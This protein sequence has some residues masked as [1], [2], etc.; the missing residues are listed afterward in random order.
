[1]DKNQLNLES[2]FDLSAKL[3]SSEDKRFILNSALLSIMGKLGITRAAVFLKDKDEFKLIIK[4][5]DIKTVIIDSCYSSGFATIDKEKHPELLNDGFSYSICLSYRDNPSAILLIGK[6]L[7]GNEI[8]QFEEQYCK[9]VS[10]IA[11][12]ALQNAEHFGELVNQKL[13]AEKKSQLLE[14]LFQISRDYSLLLTRDKIIQMTSYSLMGQL[15]INK[16]AIVIKSENGSPD[17]IYNR[18]DSKFSF[19][20]LKSLLDLK[21]IEFS[22]DYSRN[23]LNQNDKDYLSNKNVKIISSMSIHGKVKGFFLIGPKLNSEKLNEDDIQFIEA[24]GNTTIVALENERLVSE[25]I[26]KKQLEN[27]MNLALEI[28]RGLFPNSP[29]KLNNYDIYG[30]SI[31]SKQV[32]GDYYDHIRIDDNQIFLLIADVSGKGIPAAMIMANIQSTLRLLVPMKMELEEILLKINKIVYENTSSDKFVTFF[33]G[34]LNLKNN[35]FEYINAG[36]NP[37]YL[38]RDNKFIELREGGL[39]LGLM[40]SGISYEKGN[41]NIQENDSLILFTD[42]ITEALNEENEEYG[43]SR[44]KEFITEN[45]E[46]DSETFSNELVDEIK[47]FSFGSGQYDDITLINLK[48]N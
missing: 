37:P 21:E 40:D 47:K 7:N 25:E 33:G 8:S 11:S 43:E 34:I 22:D 18:F 32:G 15:M 6:K 41:I 44:L 16:F 1:M 45:H 35:S 38:F 28:Q 4:K 17:L 46:K 10:T 23:Y 5:G 39:I 2:L 27:E 12:L 3:N 9:L 20:I 36:H 26:K 19:D 30:L 24:L 13:K 48:R 42:G 14:T 29:P 31:P